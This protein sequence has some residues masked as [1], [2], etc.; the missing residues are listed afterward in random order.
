MVRYRGVSISCRAFVETLKWR[1]L[2]K[3]IGHWGLTKCLVV[4]F[5]WDEWVVCH[6]E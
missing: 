5:V 4:G 3:N 1:P 2:R 6:V